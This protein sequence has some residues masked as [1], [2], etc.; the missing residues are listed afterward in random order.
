MFANSVCTLLHILMLLLW[1]CA[2]ELWKKE[3]LDDLSQILHIYFAMWEYLEFCFPQG[4]FKSMK[5]LDV[6][7][8]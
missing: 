5:N 6:H 7:P 2:W 3:I 8:L 1:E 4:A